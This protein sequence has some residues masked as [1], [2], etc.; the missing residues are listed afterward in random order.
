MSGGYLTVL[1]L[2]MVLLCVDASDHRSEPMLVTVDKRSLA[3]H[4]NSS[5]EDA[6]EVFSN[7]YNNL[8]QE[9]GTLKTKRVANDPD[10][11]QC[12]KGKGR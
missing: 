11:I 3:L 9:D 2:P 4:F 6:N 1:L 5:E 12:Y 8:F 10:S 7:I